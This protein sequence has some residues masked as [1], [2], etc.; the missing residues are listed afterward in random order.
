MDCGG[1]LELWISGS[2][3]DELL[4]GTGPPA[5]VGKLRMKSTKGKTPNEYEG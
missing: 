4:S 1:S 5:T 2:W 3:Q